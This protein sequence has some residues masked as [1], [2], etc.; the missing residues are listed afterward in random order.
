MGYNVN[1]KIALSQNQRWGIL[2][3]LVDE[4][5]MTV[6]EIR[7]H[8]QWLIRRTTNNRNFDDARQKWQNDIDHMSD[9]LSDNGTVVDVKSIKKVNYKTK[10]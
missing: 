7:S 2:E 5:I 8:L 9:Y 10:K 4:H 1:S 3:L 6:T